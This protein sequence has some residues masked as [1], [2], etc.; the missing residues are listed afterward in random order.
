MQHTDSL[1]FGERESAKQAVLHAM[2]RRVGLTLARACVDL[3]LHYSDV[4]QWTHD[5]PD[6]GAQVRHVRALMREALGDVAEGVLAEQII[7]G[8]VKAA[9][10][11]LA[12]VHRERG[13]GKDEPKTLDITAQTIIIRDDIP[14]APPTP[15]PPVS[16]TVQ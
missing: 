14:D 4:Y 9:Q 2:R 15:S 11:Y 16:T 5:D 12:T 13:Y 10:N 1:T 6:F 8:D 7:D 3:G